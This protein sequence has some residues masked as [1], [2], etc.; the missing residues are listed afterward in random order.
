M[1]DREIVSLVWHRSGLQIEVG[2]VEGEPEHWIGS[3]VV[4]AVLA[5]D[6]GLSLIPTSD[7]AVRWVRG[8]C[9]CKADTVAPPFP[10]RVPSL[11]RSIRRKEDRPSFSIG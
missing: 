10:A 2:Y 8:P 6:A 11:R 5:G 4:A 1:A 3:G 9:S 7:D